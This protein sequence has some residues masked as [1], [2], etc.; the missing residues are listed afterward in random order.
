M[1]LDNIKWKTYYKNIRKGRQPR[2]LILDTLKRFAQEPPIDMPKA[3]DLGCGDGT[4]TA[5]LL[6]NG[7]HVLAIDSEPAAFEHLNAKIPAEAQDRLQTQVASFEAA[8]L[9]PANLIHAS[10]SIP[11]CQPQHFD[12]L[13]QQIVDN[14]VS[15]GR[16]AGEL[17]GVNDSWAV[18]PKMTFFNREQVET[19]LAPFEVEQLQEEE[20]DSRSTLGPKHWHLFHI[21]ARK[22]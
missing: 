9:A 16:F 10:Y 22:R 11:F 1:E 4:E 12:A 6:A 19:L 18:N 8:A 15:G 21:I 3:V 17:F 7:W 13:W 2:P 14:I 20:E 5:L